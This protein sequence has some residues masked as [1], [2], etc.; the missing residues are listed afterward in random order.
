MAKWSYHGNIEYVISSP[1]GL[2]RSIGKMEATIHL[3]KLS[4]NLKDLYTSFVSLSGYRDNVERNPK[5][6]HQNGMIYFFNS[7]LLR[8][9]FTDMA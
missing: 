3:L 2:F 5:P 8:A 1:F 7:L 4:T 6:C 9:P